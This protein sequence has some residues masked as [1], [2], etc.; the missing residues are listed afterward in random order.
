MKRSAPDVFLTTVAYPIKNTP[1]FNAV[2]DRVVLDQPW[3][4]ATDRDF[5]IRGR[6]SRTY[7]GHANDLLKYEVE[8]HRAEEGS[9][10]E[11]AEVKLAPQ[12][13]VILSLL[14]QVGVSV[15]GHP[16]YEA[17]DVLCSYKDDL[18]R[19]RG[20]FALDG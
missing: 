4:Q 16:G 15:V 19:V 18:A 12:E 6:H 3:E 14:K 5:R 11:E 7:Y 9:A 10:L 20:A 17:E 2:A 1:Y 13:P 8:A